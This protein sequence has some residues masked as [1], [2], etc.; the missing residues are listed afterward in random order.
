MARLA[1]I[2]GFLLVFSALHAHA[3]LTLKE[4]IDK[5]G[6]ECDSQIS[7]LNTARD[8]A[9][10]QVAA[11]ALHNCARP[12]V[13]DNALC[14]GVLDPTEGDSLSK[15]SQQELMKCSLKTSVFCPTETTHLQSLA[16]KLE[17]G[18]TLSPEQQREVRSKYLALAEC[19]K[20]HRSQF[21]GA[22][23]A[24]IDLMSKFHGDGEY[25]QDGE[26]SGNDGSGGGGKTAII[27]V[28]ILLVALGAAG[29]GFYFYSRRQQAQHLS[30]QLATVQAVPADAVGMVVQG[31]VVQEPPPPPTSMVYAT[32]PADPMDSGAYDPHDSKHNHNVM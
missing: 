4:C 1:L 23:G 19:M 9:T 28:V 32:V 15:A 12:I 2:C 21:T 14:A 3:A 13:R 11:L 18:K 5:V 22:C 6:D 29:A 25:W 30:N 16:M 8:Q 27:V 24:V 26:D 7:A 31:Q 10:A 20:S 17:S